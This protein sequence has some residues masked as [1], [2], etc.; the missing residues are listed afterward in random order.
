MNFEFR[1]SQCLIAQ[2]WHNSF[3]SAFN[4]VSK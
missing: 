1:A 3:D 4:W 2:L